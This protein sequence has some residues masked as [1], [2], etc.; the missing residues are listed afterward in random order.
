[1]LKVAAAAPEV[2]DGKDLRATRYIVKLCSCASILSFRKNPRNKMTLP[3]YDSIPLPMPILRTF[4]ASAS[5]I[6][7]K[8]AHVL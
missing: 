1:M 3:D 2:V 5:N 4:T 6:M 8:I 7:Q